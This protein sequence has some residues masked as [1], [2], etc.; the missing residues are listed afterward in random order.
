MKTRTVHT[1]STVACVIHP[2][3]SEISTDKTFAAITIM[4][5]A[6]FRSDA[7]RYMDGR[8]IS[9]PDAGYCVHCT[10]SSED[11]QMALISLLILRIIIVYYPPHAH[12][13]DLATAE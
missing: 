7:D 12:Y 9:S 11:T 3:R 10:R 1:C 2:F 4:S 13:H 6:S 5:T 8:L